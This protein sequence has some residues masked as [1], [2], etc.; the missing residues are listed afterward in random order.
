MLNEEEKKEQ[1]M[2]RKFG[3][4]ESGGRGRVRSTGERLTA[5]ERKTLSDGRGNC[6]RQERT[7]TAGPERY[8][9][10]EPEF[11]G[12]SVLEERRPGKLV[13]GWT[14]TC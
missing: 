14:R 11:S 1:E 4:T 12:D 3:V 7:S 2:T 13:G 6:T 8:K 9:A 5:W 10:E